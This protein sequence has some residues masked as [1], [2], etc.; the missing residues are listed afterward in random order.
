MKKICCLFLVLTLLLSACGKKEEPP[1]EIIPKEPEIIQTENSFL[2]AERAFVYD[3]TQE[4][5]IYLQGDLEER[6][7]PASITK[8]FTA[9]TAL[10]Y[11][12]ADTYITAGNELDLVDSAAS[13]AGLKKGN[14]L[15]VDMLIKCLLLPSGAD[16]AYILA[17]N[18]G[19]VLSGDYSL[20]PQEAHDVFVE[21]MNRIALELGIED[22]NFVTVDGLHDDNHYISFKSY[23]KIAELAL[24]NDII[25]QTVSMHK[26]LIKFADGNSITVYNVN[27]LVNPS[28]EYYVENACGLKSGR[29]SAAGCNLLSA[30]RYGDRH[31]VVG[32]FG[33]PTVADRL[34]NSVVLIEAYDNLSENFFRMLKEAESADSASSF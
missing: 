28:S 4:R 16:A 2:S 32:V 6:V 11:L 13:V 10:Q 7:Y 22:T 3:C 8:L 17:A 14:T 15:T 25:S 23:V 9:Y 30:F 33:C 26:A 34:E 5:Y 18:T 27:L 20:S 24:C 29:T 19:Y 12:D 21:E 31:I 1:V